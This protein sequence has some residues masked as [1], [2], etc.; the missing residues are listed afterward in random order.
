MGKLN[1][2]VVLINSSIVTLFLEYAI[3]YS[4]VNQ[5]KVSDSLFLQERKLKPKNELEVWLI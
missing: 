3:E 5:I 4:G 2:Q 1:K